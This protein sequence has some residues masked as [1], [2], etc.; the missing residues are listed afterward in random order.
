MVKEILHSY[1]SDTS[2]AE[3]RRSLKTLSLKVWSAVDGSEAVLYVKYPARED[4]HISKMQ[5]LRLHKTQRRLSSRL[6]IYLQC[7][8]NSITVIGSMD[9]SVRS[10]P[11]LQ[12]VPLTLCELQWGKTIVRANVQLNGN[13][14]KVDRVILEE[15]YG[16]ETKGS[17]E[18][19]E[20][21]P[22]IISV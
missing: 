11:A 16:E 2:H 1:S 4:A 6:D 13:L 8:I 22:V 14:Q 19:Q 7:F 17:Q 20:G 9:K 15:K 5:V 10:F 12:A 3:H 18:L 21:L